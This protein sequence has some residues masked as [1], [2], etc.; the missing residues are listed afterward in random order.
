MAD[1]AQTQS[2]G[3]DAADIVAD[4]WTVRALPH[5]I[6]TRTSQYQ[7][8]VR[9]SV[10]DAIHGHGKSLTDVEVCGVLVGD[11]FRDEHG[12]YLHISHSIRGDHA[13]G[14]AAQVTFTAE[15]WAGIQ[16]TMDR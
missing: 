14:H 10:L 1:G 7:A 3:P 2:T 11:V 16:A 5:V 8:V 13:A 12:P 6:G 15:T 9:R 4:E